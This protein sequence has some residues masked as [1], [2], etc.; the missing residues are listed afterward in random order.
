LIKNERKRIR[1]RRLNQEVQVVL[2]AQAVQ[3]AQAA[4]AVLVTQ[5]NLQEHLK[6]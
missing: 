3:V 6:E 1:K 4:L 2:A 5:V